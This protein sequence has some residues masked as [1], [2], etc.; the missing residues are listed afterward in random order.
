MNLNE[1]QPLST[2]VSVSSPT[3]NL[4][5]RHL[6]T[7]KHYLLAGGVGLITP[8]PVV[9]LYRSQGVMLNDLLLFFLILFSGLYLFNTF[10]KMII[11]TFDFKAITLSTS[12]FFGALIFYIGVTLLAML[13]LGHQALALDLES[14]TLFEQIFFYVAVAGI[15]GLSASISF[16]SF[17]LGNMDYSFLLLNLLRYSLFALGLSLMGEAMT[18]L[19]LV[20]TKMDIIIALTFVALILTENFIFLAYSVVCLLMGIIFVLL[21]YRRVDITQLKEVEQ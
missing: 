16:I 15:F 4:F 2:T 14:A 12:V 6:L 21:A 18:V 19:L 20:L 8:I 9:L 7:R 1:N 17:E 11:D 10:R 13:L 3:N 5:R